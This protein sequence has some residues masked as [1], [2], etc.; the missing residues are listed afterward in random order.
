M[1]QTIEDAL[2]LC[3]VGLGLQNANNCHLISMTFQSGI[4]IVVAPV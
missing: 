2:I 4:W 1:L 3:G